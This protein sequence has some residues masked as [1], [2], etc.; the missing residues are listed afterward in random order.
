MERDREG[1]RGLRRE[2]RAHL[3]KGGKRDGL[4]RDVER[5]KR[6]F[7]ERPWEKD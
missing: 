6:Y 1:R 4:E 7:E 3:E 5:A 2:R